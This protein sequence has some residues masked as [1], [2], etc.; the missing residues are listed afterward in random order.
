M[1][2][3]WGSTF[4]PSSKGYHWNLSHIG[5]NKKG[6]KWKTL[7]CCISWDL[8]AIRLNYLGLPEGCLRQ[9]QP[10]P[11]ITA[12]NSQRHALGEKYKE[13]REM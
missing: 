1:S 2:E 5:T 4:T 13:I 9:M 12:S 6:K 10:S 3:L 7:T 11:S 8:Q